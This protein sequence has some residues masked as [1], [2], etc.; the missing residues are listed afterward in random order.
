MAEPG[1]G[2]KPPIKTIAAERNTPKLMNT[3]PLG[4]KESSVFSPLSTPIKNIEA[5]FA[6]T[7][8][9][10][11]SKDKGT[12]NKQNRDLL[13]EKD[14]M[15]RIK[16]A[17]EINTQR[18]I[19]MQGDQTPEE[20]KQI[21]LLRK[22][23]LAYLEAQFN[24][25][26]DL[27]KVVNTFETMSKASEAVLSLKEALL[28]FPIIHGEILMQKY[29]H[30]D[31]TNTAKATVLQLLAGHTRLVKKTERGD[32]FFTLSP[33]EQEA[34]SKG[35]GE[36]ANFVQNR[37]LIDFPQ[38]R[39]Q[40]KI[41]VGDIIASYFNFPGENGA[42]YE[43]FTEWFTEVTLSI[44]HPLGW[45]F[46]SG[47]SARGKIDNQKLL[48]KFVMDHS[49]LLPF[50]RPD[51]FRGIVK[52][53]L[54]NDIHVLQTLE[55]KHNLLGRYKLPFS[56]VE[57]WLKN[58][59]PSLENL[60]MIDKLEAQQPGICK[61]LYEEFG[62]IDFARY[63]LELLVR[64]YQERDRTDL[65]YGIILF[66][67]TDHNGAFAQKP[68][69]LGNLLKQVESR[70]LLRVIEAGGVNQGLQRLSSLQRRYGRISFG[71][72]GGHGTQRSIQF[73]QGEVHAFTDRTSLK[74]ESGELI[75]DAIQNQSRRA[76]AAARLL[77]GENAP[78]VLVSCS[79][80]Q[81]Q[82]IG[83]RISELKDFSI[84]APATDTAL[85]DIEVIYGENGRIIDIKPTYRDDV[86][87]L[88][89][90]GKPIDSDKTTE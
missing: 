8:P 22:D 68:E 70:Y 52:N 67:R 49:H 16:Q 3:Q 21:D 82:G 37:F 77:F 46:V 83:Q 28:T 35:V 55:A 36:A 18:N 44:P 51:H 48:Q 86:R 31:T 62:I 30:H 71:I 61:I 85:R 23:L 69:V 6:T 58:P 12:D 38:L 26:D 84:Q 27:T 74:K 19:L 17:D 9:A 54:H 80:G 2:I 7:A 59:Q 88:Y 63:P 42:Q 73:G 32:S 20:S 79:T 60:A 45:A 57:E 39:D 50:N 40:P 5:T 90:A 25:T 10:S 72:I 87:R 14:L 24:T 66:P 13:L 64:Q 78:L 81:E 1:E 53:V 11:S 89:V 15:E 75:L 47:A 33:Q 29:M 65:P 41:R 34:V 43:R 76:Q 4:T 56:L